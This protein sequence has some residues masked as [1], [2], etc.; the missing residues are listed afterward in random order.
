MPSGGFP[1]GFPGGGGFGGP[2]GG[3]FVFS[4]NGGAGAQHLGRALKTA[5]ERP[6]SSPGDLA[7][8]EVRRRGS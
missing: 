8:P 6:A 2:G 7:H 3:T 5:L 1:G 4:S